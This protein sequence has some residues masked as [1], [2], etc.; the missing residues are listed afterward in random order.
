MF[1]RLWAGPSCIARAISRRRSSWAV[2]TIRDIPGAPSSAARLAPLSAAGSSAPSSD[3][4]AEAGSHLAQRFAESG[5]DLALAVEDLD[6]CLHDGGAAGQ[7]DELG[8]ERDDIL[9]RGCL[10][11]AGELVG[12]LGPFELVPLRL[13]PG[14]RDEHV[15]LGELTVEGREVAADARRQLPEGIR[16]RARFYRGHGRAINPPASGSSPGASRRRRPASGR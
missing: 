11:Q 6:L 7:V 9:G 1:V 14:L 3:R 5:E 13:R 10:G 4:D 16:C 8:I 12:R 2:R 15:D